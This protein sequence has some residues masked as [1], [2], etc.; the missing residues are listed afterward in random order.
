MQIQP[1]TSQNKFQPTRAPLPLPQSAALP[2]PETTDRATFG[3]VPPAPQPARQPEPAPPASQPATP[4]APPPVQLALLESG[5][6]TPASAPLT[7]VLEQAANSA[8]IHDAADYH[9]QQ[10]YLVMDRMIAGTDP[11]TGLLPLHFETR[12]GQ[13]V[14]TDHIAA[15]LDMG[16]QT[17]GLVMTAEVARRHGDED[18]AQHYLQAAEK[19]WSRGK[20]LLAEGDAFVQRRDF[21]EDGS[22]KSSE[23]GEPG[24]SAL[25][26]DNMSRINPRGYAFRG[27]ADLFLA[28]A[29]PEY[30]SDF[31]RYFQAWVRDF[32]DPDQGGFFLHA[33]LDNPT[34]HQERSSF[35]EPGGKDSSYDGQAGAKGN[36]STIYALS[37]VLLPANQVL[38]TPQTQQLVQEQMDLILD[39]FQRQNGMLWENYTADFQPIS[40]DWQ[41]QPRADGQSSHVAIG[42]HTAMAAQQL[43]EGAS[44]LRA[45]EAIDQARYNTYV[46]RTVELFEDFANQSG[47]IDWQT[48]A[49]HNAIRVEEPEQEKRWIQDWVD[50]SWQQAELIQSLVRLKEVGRLADLQGPEGKTG[51]DLLRAATSYYRNHYGQSDNPSYQ[52]YFGNPDVYHVPQVALYLQQA[53]QGE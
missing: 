13:V 51:N 28:T 21:N 49:V 53:L 8:L 23:R 34:D 48:G 38:A 7:S 11:V 2:E 37:G 27:A 20:Q 44:Q 52:D 29:K 31:N 24:K 4:P 10:A 40:Q 1:L 12:D 5:P 45:Q 6:A 46:D 50:A 22:V 42:G 43:L 9:R 14:A 19:N 36:D 32:H 30:K 33:N 26:Q 15:G 17:A 39:R 25:E 16:R 41:N 35:K 47:A 3:P 18:R